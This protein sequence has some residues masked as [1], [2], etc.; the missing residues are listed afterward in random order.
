MLW[1]NN[2][3]MCR[4]GLRIFH[5]VSALISL[6]WLVFLLC[7]FIR[8]IRICIYINHVFCKTLWYILGVTVCYSPLCFL[9]LFVTVID[10]YFFHSNKRETKSSILCPLFSLTTP[11][12]T[13]IFKQICSKSDVFNSNEFTTELIYFSSY[14]KYF[15]LSPGSRKENFG[16]N[17]NVHCSLY[18]SNELIL[19][20]I[21]NYAVQLTLMSVSCTALFRTLTSLH[22][23]RLKTTTLPWISD[24]WKN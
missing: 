11:R 19:I 4:Y 22:E 3:I 16:C 5:D 18:A 14:N 1:T 9:T 20:E 2:S 21:W 13:V 23:I 17:N 7:M 15:S 12:N 24:Y 10:L 6:L 8:N